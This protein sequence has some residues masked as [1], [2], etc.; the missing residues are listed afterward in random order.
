MS[1]LKRIT[2]TLLLS[3][4]LVLSTALY[5]KTFYINAQVAFLSSMFVIV[6]ASLAYKKMVITK[7]D[8]EAYE[9]DRDLLDTIEDP[10]G[11]YDKVNDEVR[12]GAL[13]YEDNINEAPPEELDLK[14]IVKEEKAKIKTFSVK[15]MKHGAR[16]SVSIF[17]IV[18]YIFLVLGFIALENNNLLDLSAYLPSL[19]IGIVV[20][21]LVSKEI[22]A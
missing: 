9:G 16:G 19:F 2:S 6:G 4:A 8:A 11:L 7:V 3:E 5:S 17:R 22:A 14:T 13:G 12:E 1:I 10:H 20:G 15:S 18:P 21:S